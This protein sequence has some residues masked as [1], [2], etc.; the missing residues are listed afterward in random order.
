MHTACTMNADC[1]DPKAVCVKPGPDSGI[2]AAGECAPAIGPC[3]ATDMCDQDSYCCGTDCRL[4]NGDKVCIPFDY[5]ATPDCKLPGAAL[6]VTSI[7]P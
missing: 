2:T 7:G 3:D 1:T 4:D 6:G 5:G